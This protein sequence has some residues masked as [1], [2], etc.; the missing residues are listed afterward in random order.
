MCGI[1]AI[2]G[3]SESSETWRSK[4]LQMS[5]LIRHRGPDWN[6]IYCGKNCILAHERLAIV[7]LISGA[8]PIKDKSGEIIMTVNAEIYNYKE[9]KKHL[10]SIDS[11]YENEFITDSD[12]EVLIHLYKEYGVEFFRC[13]FL[14]LLWRCNC[15]ES[16]HM[17]IDFDKVSLLQVTV[18]VKLKVYMWI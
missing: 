9:L 5:K 14:A 17:Y 3:L 16:L 15:V 12:C 1:L 6:G 7:G 2:F 18:L 11:K 10:I 8:Q 4:V 13:N